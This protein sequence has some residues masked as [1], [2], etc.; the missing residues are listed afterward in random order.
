MALPAS[1]HATRSSPCPISPRSRLCASPWRAGWGEEKP[2]VIS[3]VP[4]VNQPEAQQQVILI[5]TSD[6]SIQWALCGKPTVFVI[7]LSY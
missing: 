6:N 1:Y 3:W 7:L 4:T 5:Q 2:S